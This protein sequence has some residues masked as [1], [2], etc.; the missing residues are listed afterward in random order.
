MVL[1]LNG[2]HCSR[3]TA[4]RYKSVCYIWVDIERAVSVKGDCHQLTATI[5]IFK[6]FALKP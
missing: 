1:R 3:F 2:V 5:V 6:T 4:F